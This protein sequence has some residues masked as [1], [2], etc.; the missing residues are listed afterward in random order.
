MKAGGGRA[1]SA[2][3]GLAWNTAGVARR[4]AA[5]TDRR[6]R[7]RE[8]RGTTVSCRSVATVF[9]ERHDPV[10]T[11]DSLSERLLSPEE[12]LSSTPSL[13]KPPL[14]RTVARD[15]MRRGRY[16]TQACARHSKLSNARGR[17]CGGP[18]G[19]DCAR[20]AWPGSPRTTRTTRR[21]PRPSPTPRCGAARGPSHPSCPAP[22]DA[23]APSTAG[24]QPAT[25]GH[26]AR[27]RLHPTPRHSPRH[28]PAE[29][30]RGHRPGLAGA[31]GTAGHRPFAAG[32]RI[33]THSTWC[34]IGNRSNTRSV[35]TR[36]PPSRKYARSRA[37]AAGSQ[38]T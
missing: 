10:N 31:E 36:Y 30:G 22:T 7:S 18:T 5:T 16:A 19:N 8:A 27:R 26:T 9:V 3:R 13:V 24:Q 20:T 34:V 28:A 23:S 21:N 4:R 25:S 15:G 12:V 6:P 37:R 38:A 2:A 1:A 35:R 11:F 32:S 29:T 17:D 14:T 33:A